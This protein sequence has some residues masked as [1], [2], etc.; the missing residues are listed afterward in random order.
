MQHVHTHIHIHTHREKGS[1]GLQ[2]GISSCMLSVLSK[3]SSRSLTFSDRYH[4]LPS[5]V[6][7]FTAGSVAAKLPNHHRWRRVMCSRRMGNRPPWQLQSRGSHLVQLREVTSVT[8]SIRR[9]L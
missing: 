7:V 2:A 8:S 4:T 1:R 9:R 3:L 6:V 5:M